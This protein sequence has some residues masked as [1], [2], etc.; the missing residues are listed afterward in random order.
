M[1]IH[2]KHFQNYM[3]H[4]LAIKF[5]FCHEH[6]S[7]YYPQANGQVEVVNQTF[8][9]IFKWMGIPLVVDSILGASTPS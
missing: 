6:S 8:N 9:T 7:P 3:M 1:T 4:G 5:G 2:G